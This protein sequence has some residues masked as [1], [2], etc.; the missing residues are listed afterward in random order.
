MPNEQTCGECRWFRVSKL[1][2]MYLTICDYL[3]PYK[4]HPEKGY[5]C[6]HHEPKEEEMSKDMEKPIFKEA[7]MYLINDYSLENDSDTP[8]YILANYLKDCL[9]AF[10]EAVNARR[11]WHSTENTK[12]WHTK[13]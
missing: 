1:F 2:D 9:D 6:P 10:D 13:I 5:T 11:E 7:L 12:D 3:N 8:D 4:L